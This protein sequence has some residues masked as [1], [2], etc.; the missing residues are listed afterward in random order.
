MNR[1]ERRSSAKRGLTSSGPGK[2]A[3]G[4]AQMFEAGLWHHQEGRLAEAEACYRRVLSVQPG[5]PDA[6]YSL[7]LIARQSGRSDIA[8]DLIG[9]AIKRKQG[10][11]LYF[12][13]H[14]AALQDLMRFEEALASYDR[15][16]A[17]LPDNAEAFYNRGFVLCALNRSGE[18]LA[19]FERACSLAPQFA[20]AWNNCGALLQQMKQSDRA[21]A[22]FDKALA[23]KPDFAEAWVGRGH[24]YSDLKRHEEALAAYDRAI[25]IQPGSHEAWLGRGSLLGELKR[26]DEALASFEKALAL[27]PQVAQAWNNNGVLLHQVNQFGRAIASFDKALALRPDLAEAWIGRGNVCNDLKRYDEAL[28]AYERAL[29]LDPGLAKGW[30]GRGHACSDLARHEEAFEAY[31]RAFRLEPDLLGVEGMRLFSK[32]R[33]C[34]WRNFRAERESLVA[35]VES[36]KGNTTPFPFLAI[37]TSSAHLGSLARLWSNKLHPRSTNPAW[38]GEIYRHDRIRVAYVSADFRE[39]AVSYLIAGMFERHDKS[40]FELVA[41]SLGADD[42][43]DVRRRLSRSFEHFIDARALG[44]A[45]IASR[46][47]DAETDL[48]IDLNGFTDGA[49]TGIFAR[50]PAPVQ[51]NY[52]GYPGTMGADYMDYVVADRTLIPDAC[53]DHYAEKIVYLPDSYMPHDDASRVISE[54]VFDR[55]EY[56]LPQDGFVFCCFNQSYKLNPEV[57]D[58]WARILNAVNESVLWLSAANPITVRNLRNEIG[59]RGVDPDRL[60]FA[61]RLPSSSDHLARHRV[62]DLFLDTLPYNAHTTASDALWAGL[63]VLTRIGET[64][65]GRVAASLLNAV[66][67]PELITQTQEQYE[68]AAIELASSPE[69]LTAIKAKLT[70]NRLTRPLFD[71]PL[72]TRNIE[73]AF[74]AMYARYQEGLPP[75]HIYVRS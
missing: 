53:R 49:R 10:E 58:G 56:G 54:R 8:A 44:D 11:P 35:A 41:V 7:G 30:G 55:G 4:V 71:T 15:A 70:Q 43:S 64:F 47:R 34:D 37:S 66:G 6:L 31:D 69:K 39:H 13:Y 36:G 22:H 27:N 65:A 19:S 38:R 1:R 14:A 9:Q 16:V 20:E 32:M 17:L 45:E 57:F 5:H 67:L 48:L 75:D 28:A 24:V 18:A 25:A 42:S 50:R 51:V 63:P 73:S 3:S 68:N 60:V 26:N 72:F 52:L 61:E 12:L 23:L 62:A 46:I 2:A 33:V 40:R 59:A 74:E 21:M 29:A